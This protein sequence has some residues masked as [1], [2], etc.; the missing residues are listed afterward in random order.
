[1]KQEEEVAALCSVTYDAD[2]DDV[3]VTFKVQS[4]AYKDLIMRLA[5]RPDIQVSIRGDKMYAKINETS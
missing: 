4:E 2:S 3:Y 1:M 5:S